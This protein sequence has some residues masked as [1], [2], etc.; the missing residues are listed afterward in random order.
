MQPNRH[1]QADH[2]RE[3]FATLPASSSSPRPFEHVLQAL[4]NY[5]SVDTTYEYHPNMD[6]DF[7]N[8]V[9]HSLNP[10]ALRQ[11]NAFLPPGFALRFS[12]C[13]KDESIVET[14]VILTPKT[15]VAFDV[16]APSRPAQVP[17]DLDAVAHALSGTEEFVSPMFAAKEPCIVSCAMELVQWELDHTSDIDRKHYCFRWLRKLARSQGRLPLSLY[18]DNLR[19][20][21]GQI[22]GGGY[23]DIFIGRLGEEQVCLKVLRIFQ[24]N[25]HK[26]RVVKRFCHETLVWRQ[27][28]HPNVLRFLGVTETLF[29]GK[30]SLVSPFMKNGN[31][32]S[33]LEANPSHD[34]LAVVMDIANGLDYLHS[35][36]PPIV[37][38]DLRG[39]NVLVQDDL[40]CCIADFGLA[41]VSDSQPLTTTSSD[42]AP[43]GSIRWSAPEVFS[44]KRFPDAPREKR[45]VFAFACTIVEV[46]LGKPPFAQIATDYEVMLEIHEGRRPPQP[47]PSLLPANLWNLVELCWSQDPSERM[48]M[49][50]VWFKFDLEWPAE[51]KLR[52]H[53]SS[54]LPQVTSLASFHFRSDKSSPFDSVILCF[55]VAGNHI[56]A[57]LFFLY[58]QHMTRHPRDVNI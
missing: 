42:T 50:E 54:H 14:V 28:R 53:T 13:N 23:S 30:F 49:N 8:L 22:G 12:C 6:E 41:M 4:E 26:K 11:L 24:S 2:L 19:I 10:V 16:R 35:F 55:N 47:P 34:R 29:P 43:K 3:L 20:E 32:I 18:L 33:Y 21:S 56:T 25:G 40:T 1:S 58:P 39:S 46:Y 37:H 48:S 17:T 52:Q 15:A 31:V 36:S 44:P 27:L 9:L 45:D 38:G 51:T 7:R 5:K 57:V